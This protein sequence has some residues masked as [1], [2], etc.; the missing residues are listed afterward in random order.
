MR[1]LVQE[2]ILKNMNKRMISFL[3][4]MLIIIIATT[5]IF[6]NIQAMEIPETTINIDI[7]EINADEAIIQVTIDINNPNIF[8]LSTKNF[9]IVTTTPN[10]YEV[11]RTSIKDREILP[12]NNKTFTVTSVFAFDGVCPSMLTSKIT[13]DISVNI[14]FIQ[15]T[16]PLTIN[17]VTSVKGAVKQI[18]PPIIHTKTKFG[19]IT[20]E[21]ISLTS[22]IE[23]YNPNTFDVYVKDI[24]IDVRVETG[25][26]M[27]YFLNISGDNMLAAK[28]NTFLKSDGILKINV[29]D[30]EKL[31]IDITG[32][33]GVIVAGIDESI[34]FSSISEIEVPSIGNLISDLSTDSIIWGDYTAT[35]KGLID[36]TTFEIYNP[37]KINFEARNITLAIYRVDDDDEELIST[38]NLGREI[39][40]AEDTTTVEGELLI[41]YSKLVSIGKRV[42]PDWLKVVIR[43]ELSLPGVEHSIK[44]GVIA[45]QDF[46]LFKQG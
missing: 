25:E 10:G 13:G 2:F 4:V 43:I 5:F 15:K 22:T 39:I 17:I 27:G 46:H 41:P 23:I 21:S 3:I 44:I 37:N 19:D 24:S 1:K 30:A 28:E 40:K 6:V 26:N 8:G 42:L 32:T 9:E 7:K 29:L 35:L 20:H 33:V 36:H 14:C 16:L 34:L 18:V 12:Q 31:L 11:D 45:Y 38:I